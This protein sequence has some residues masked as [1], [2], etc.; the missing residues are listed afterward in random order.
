MRLYRFLRLAMLL[1]GQQE[2]ARSHSAAY[3]GSGLA[4]MLC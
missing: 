4:A 1:A 2:A 3:A